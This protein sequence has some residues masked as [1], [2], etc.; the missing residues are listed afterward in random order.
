LEISNSLITA[1]SGKQAHE[2][3]GHQ[4][5]IKAEGV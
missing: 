5:Q 1:A 3:M 4:M 2:Q